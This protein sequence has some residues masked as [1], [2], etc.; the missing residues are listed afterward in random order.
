MLLLTNL[1]DI[2]SFDHPCGLTIGSFDG[3]HLGHQVLLN[4]LKAK[5]LPHQPL[6]V[7]TFS[8]HPSHH[9]NPQSPVPLICPPLQKAKLLSKYG[10]DIIFLVPF[11]TAFAR[12]PYD[13]FLKKLKQSLNF[14]DLCLGDGSMFG[15]NREGNAINVKQ[16]ADKLH[17]K[18]DYLKK[19]LVNGSPVSSGRIRKLIEEGK[20]AEVKQCL[21]RPYSLMGAL[22]R[23]ENNLQFRLSGVCL[24]PD[25]EYLVYLQTTSQTQEYAAHVLQ[26]K[27]LIK[28]KTK[29]YTFLDQKEAEVIFIK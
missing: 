14:T 19:Y 9:F 7:F 2:P 25:G 18:A 24:P 17:F 20:L 29:N 22:I 23:D 28:I 10:A 26:K 1:N 11:D 27:Q 3:V 5:L 16:L 6:V 8:N 13:E 12:I 21:G 4:H 15:K